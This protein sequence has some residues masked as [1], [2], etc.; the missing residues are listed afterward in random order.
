MANDC[1]RF[2]CQAC[3]LLCISEHFRKA[4]GCISRP[5]VG[6]GFT[7]ALCGRRNS[8]H[9]C[10]ISSA[11]ISSANQCKRSRHPVALA[12][13]TD[14]ALG[15]NAPTNRVSIDNESSE[16]TVV[17]VTGKNHPGLLTAVT[18]LFRDLGM[19]VLKADV[20]T[21]GD[22]VNDAFYIVDLEGKQ[23]VGSAEL[24]SLEAALKA[25]VDGRPMKG[26]PSFA[27]TGAPE[28][29]S[30]TTALMGVVLSCPIAAAC[31]FTGN[32]NRAQSIAAF[33]S[34]PG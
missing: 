18:G 16:Y 8:A 2:I 12:Q 15:M 6:M 14:G 25:V 3:L 11:R 20:S 24:A 26:R 13:Q 4:T 23:I 19:D 31:T 5:L 22:E 29:G 28:R 21:T 33:D 9:L 1:G 34:D 10:R 27:K 32:Q 17:T 30:T 7:R